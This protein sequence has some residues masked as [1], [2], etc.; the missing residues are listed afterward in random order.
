MVGDSIQHQFYV[1]T[2]MQLEE[3]D[4]GLTQKDSQMTMKNASSGA[5]CAGLGGGRLV[6]IR[7]DQ[8]AIRQEVYNTVDNMNPWAVYAKNFDVLILNKGAHYVPYKTSTADTIATAMFL[9]RLTKEYPNIKIF[10]RTSS[11]G[12]PESSLYGSKAITTPLLT[13]PSSWLNITSFS[14]YQR[15]VLKYHWDSFATM[16]DVTISI[17]H[18]F[19]DKTKFSVL[20][21]AEMTLLRPDGHRCAATG[22]CE[23][24]LH[25][26]LPS[27]ID[28]W[29]VV[30]QNLL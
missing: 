19:T 2:M 1:A 30:L 6:F 12:H 22:L 9:K 26:Y 23:D 15:Y 29:V 24:E 27:V 3:V 20:H 28:N 18:T 25:Y 5:I 10:Y 17:L 21:V 14:Q 16:N 4:S 11:P 8:I 13:E 7:N